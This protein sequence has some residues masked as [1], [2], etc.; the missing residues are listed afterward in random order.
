VLPIVLGDGILLAGAGADQTILAD[1]AGLS[2]VSYSNCSRD[3]QPVLVAAGEGV[4]IT[5]LGV[6]GTTSGMTAVGLYVASGDVQVSEV[7]VEGG[8]E[9]VF[10]AGESV[11]TFADM[12]VT[13]AGH[14]AF[15][16]AGTSVVQIERADIHHNKD[17]L[18]PICE[19]TVTITTSEIHCNG[20][21]VEALGDATTTAIDNHVHGNNL[22]FAARGVGTSITARGNVIERNKIAVYEA[23][24]HVN[25]GTS[26]DPGGNT[27][28]DNRHAGV[29]LRMVPEDTY[30]VG[31][32][33]EPGVDGADS[34]GAYSG[35]VS[36]SL[37]P[38]TCP[39]HPLSSIDTAWDPECAGGFPKA[40]GYQN[41]AIDDGG[42]EGDSTI[43]VG[44][45]I[46][47][48]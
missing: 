10:I 25:L 43:P 30:A 18:E 1:A 38:E 46:V 23:F 39:T 2:D 45:L 7:R 41:V 47:S 28:Q 19:S 21:G 40:D 14:A 44:T 26:A 15:K 24:G 37:S 29:M 6:I 13:G 31:N 5:G 8:Q 11:A 33:W 12:E 16:P 34:T 35:A 4:E 3:L 32:T 48:E 36:F 27:L 42:C 17:A 22:G 20:N 9:G